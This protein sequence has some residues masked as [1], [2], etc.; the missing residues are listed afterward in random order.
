MFQVRIHW[1][2]TRDPGYLLNDDP[3]FYHDQQSYKLIIHKKISHFLFKIATVN[4]LN[5]LNEISGSVQVS[6]PA[7]QNLKFLFFLLFFLKNDVL[8][9]MD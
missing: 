7:F 1:K 2:R 6:T 5:L 9:V 8:A 4:L 3:E